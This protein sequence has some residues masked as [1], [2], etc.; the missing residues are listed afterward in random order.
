MMRETPDVQQVCIY[1]SNHV[2]GAAAAVSGTS[3]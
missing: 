1:F 2:A 3:G